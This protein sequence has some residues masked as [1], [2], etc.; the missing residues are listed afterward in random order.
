MHVRVL[1]PECHWTDPMKTHEIIDGQT[2]KLIGQ[3][4]SL[5][6]AHRRADRLDLEYGAIRY[7]V[8]R[9]EQPMADAILS[10]GPL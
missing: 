9:I 4:S 8:R 2:Q 6:R 1:S 7:H 5:R 3:Y 10:T